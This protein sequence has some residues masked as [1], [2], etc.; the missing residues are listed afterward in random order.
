ML[1]ISLG[2]FRESDLT[3]TWN[4]LCARGE[5]I[6][7]FSLLPAE[8]VIATAFGTVIDQ[9]GASRKW[10]PS[11]PRVACH[12]VD[13][14]EL[15][16]EE[17]GIHALFNHEIDKLPAG[18][19][20]ALCPASRVA[21]AAQHL[22]VE[23]VGPHL[24]V[25]TASTR[26][27]EIAAAALQISERPV[28]DNRLPSIAELRYGRRLCFDADSAEAAIKYFNL[29]V[30]PAAPEPVVVQLGGQTILAV[31]RSE[32]AEP[33]R[34]IICQAYF[35]PTARRDLSRWLKEIKNP[36]SKTKTSA[37]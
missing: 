11:G 10:Q 13:V 32:S 21:E 3:H 37:T 19:F 25:Y 5:R 1:T 34:G 31:A 15:G 16:E 30:F 4:A 6:L 35:E 14:V 26:H 20:I 8:R 9:T 22:R 27:A 12:L 28:N 29:P 33:M 18:N 2:P 17:F 24:Y 36:I 23:H 7:A